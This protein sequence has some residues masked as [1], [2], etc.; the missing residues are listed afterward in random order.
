MVT[1]GRGCGSAPCSAP[2][3]LLGVL[4]AIISNYTQAIRAECFEPGGGSVLFPG[5]VQPHE[6]WTL[7]SYWSSVL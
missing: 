4:A 2:L 6:K 3:G 1:G 5:A 7:W